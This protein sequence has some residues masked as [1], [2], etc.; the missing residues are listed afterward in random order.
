M[1]A[2][3]TCQAVNSVVEGL[4]RIIKRVGSI[5]YPTFVTERGVV[6]VGREEC[7]EP[8]LDGYEVPVETSRYLG[9]IGLRQAVVARG[10]SL[11]RY[12]QIPLPS[13]K[14]SVP[15]RTGAAVSNILVGSGR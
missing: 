12:P 5:W 9:I 7:V 6:I 14:K 15:V 3:A 11:R 2:V 10:A 4:E 13:P 1:A 8:L